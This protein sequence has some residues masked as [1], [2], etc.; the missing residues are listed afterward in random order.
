MLDTLYVSQSNIYGIIIPKPMFIQ[1]C[2]Y[3]R[4]REHNR[5]FLGFHQNSLPNKYPKTFCS[6]KY[7]LLIYIHLFVTVTTNG[8]KLHLLLQYSK[9]QMAFPTNW[10]STHLPTIV[11]IL[12]AEKFKNLT[13]IHLLEM[14][15][16]NFKF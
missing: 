11:S 3:N 5:I 14:Y 10:L 16:F 7:Y 4:K 6:T 9:K 13:V 8:V 1:Y 2:Q 15:V 12:L